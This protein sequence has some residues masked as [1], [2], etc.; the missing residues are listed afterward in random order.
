MD[1]L[2]TGLLNSRYLDVSVIQIPTVQWGL[3]SGN[4][5][6][7]NGQKEVGLQIVWNSIGI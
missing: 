6:I 4:V 5:W 3:K 7:L 1:D 2:N